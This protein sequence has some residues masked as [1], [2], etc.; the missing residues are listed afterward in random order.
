[1]ITPV[2]VPAEPAP[3]ELPVATPQ[4]EV[5]TK[6]TVE[7]ATEETQ[8]TDNEALS[9]ADQAKLDGEKPARPRR[10]RGRPPK[11]ANP[12]TEQ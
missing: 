8:A 10:P 9:E 6:E 11:K 12:T 5:A 1:M 4:A 3:T 2:D 7:K